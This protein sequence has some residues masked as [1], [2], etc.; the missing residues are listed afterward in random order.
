MALRWARIPKLP[1]FQAPESVTRKGITI[2]T[3]LLPAALG[4]SVTRT[5]ATCRLQ[6][7][8]LCGGAG[9]G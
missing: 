7:S 9:A 3:S 2:V 1:T 5:C 4:L 8:S 6:V